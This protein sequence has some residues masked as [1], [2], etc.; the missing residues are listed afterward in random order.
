MNIK[1]EIQDLFGG[2]WLNAING[3]DWLIL[4]FLFLGVFAATIG[5]AAL[6]RPAKSL[7]SRLKG[8]RSDEDRPKLTLKQAAPDTAFNKALKQ[9]EKHRSMRT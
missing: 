4:T 3:G 6:F 2:N 9:L 5:I 7:E 1:N 8:E